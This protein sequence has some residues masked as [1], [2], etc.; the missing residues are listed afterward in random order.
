MNE[1]PLSEFVAEHGQKITANLLGVT[2]GAVWQ[3]L[4]SSRSI[5]VVKSPDGDIS[6]YEKKPVGKQRPAA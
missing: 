5:T 1:I 3:M 4:N 6:A 2:Q